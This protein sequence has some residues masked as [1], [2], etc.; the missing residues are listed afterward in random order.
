MKFKYEYKYKELNILDIC[1]PHDARPIDMELFR[2]SFN[3]INHPDNF[4]PC[5]ILNP[6][7]RLP[8]DNEKCRA[9]ALSF[10]ISLDA[11]IKCYNNLTEN[12]KKKLGY[13]HIATGNVNNKDGVATKPQKHGHLSFHESKNA[14]FPEKFEIIKSLN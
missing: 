7:R 10:Y 2:W 13:T 1:P 4:L 5:I 6:S 9:C 11:A 8:D 14:N 12:A 3:K